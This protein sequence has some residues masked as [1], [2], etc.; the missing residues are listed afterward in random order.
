MVASGALKILHK[1]LANHEISSDDLIEQQHEISQ[2]RFVSLPKQPGF[3]ILLH[4][5]NDSALLR[6]VNYILYTILLP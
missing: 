6:K 4:L 2:G 5:F 1:L 3:T